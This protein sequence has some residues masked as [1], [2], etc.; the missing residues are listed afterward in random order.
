MKSII[1]LCGIGCIFLSCGAQ[2]IPQSK[3]PSVVVNAIQGKYPVAT[4]IDWKKAG[5]LYEAEI[6]RKDSADMNFRIDGNGKILM[7]KEKIPVTSLSPAIT[8]AIRASYPTYT[9]EEAERI[10]V[11]TGTL[12][13]VELDQ[14]GKKDVHLVF[15]EAGT[16]NKSFTYWD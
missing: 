15:S 4:N 5:S 14:R 7:S 16:E 12:Y 9:I 13:Q 10:E 8:A 2:D 3:V 1:L 11:A 6:D